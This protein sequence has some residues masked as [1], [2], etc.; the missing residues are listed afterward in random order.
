MIH[1]ISCGVLV[2]DGHS[3]VLG[4]ATASPRWDIPKGLA[5]AGE[6]YETAARRELDEETGLQVPSGALLSLGEYR[7]RPSKALVLYAWL[8]SDIPPADS[9]RCRS[10]FEL[11]GRPVP[12]FDRF[13]CPAWPAALSM[14]GPSMVAVL[15]PLA[16]SRGWLKP[17]QAGFKLG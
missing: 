10:T 13:A 5:D 16:A 8:V 17:T 7:Y 6:D 1:A 2:T 15:K 14:L 11:R 12:E 4:H 3:V 9:L